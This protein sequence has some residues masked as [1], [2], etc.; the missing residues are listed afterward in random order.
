VFTL[1]VESVSMDVECVGF[2]VRA[3]AFSCFPRF[4]IVALIFRLVL[5][6][7]Y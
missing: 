4:C 5:N 1:S 7:S 6:M 2:H 3:K